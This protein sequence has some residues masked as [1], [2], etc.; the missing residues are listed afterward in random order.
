ME[1]KLVLKVLFYGPIQS[2]RRINLSLTICFLQRFDVDRFH[3]EY[4][5]RQAL[6]IQWSAQI[7]RDDRFF[8]LP[9]SCIEKFLR[10]SSSGTARRKSSWLL[11]LIV[12]P[13]N[14]RN[15]LLQIY[16]ALLR[17]LSQQNLA[18]CRN[19]LESPNADRY[20]CTSG[21]SRFRK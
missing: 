18:F 10:S 13:Q 17:T 11:G 8:R 16:V 1:E 21:F 6:R 3:L 2:R 7:P 5:L 9:L 4:R 19:A 14:G 15:F 20:S 12:E